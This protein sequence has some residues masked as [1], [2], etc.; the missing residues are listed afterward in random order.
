[1]AALTAEACSSTVSHWEDIFARYQDVLVRICVAAGAHLGIPV[2]YVNHD[3]Y[4]ETLTRCLS[5]SQL[6]SLFPEV[7]ASQAERARARALP[8]G[9]QIAYY[10]SRLNRF[11][12]LIGSEEAQEALRGVRSAPIPALP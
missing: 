1:I 2:F 7:V 11:D 4:E 8:P 12:G 6:R 5:P 3:C 9:E 10:V